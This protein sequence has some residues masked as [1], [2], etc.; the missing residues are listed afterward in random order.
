M[1]DQF[2]AEYE[3]QIANRARVLSRAR[4]RTLH[5]HPANG[6]IA[7]FL[8]QVASTLRRDG[9]AADALNSAAERQGASMLRGGHPIVD[10][11]QYYGDVCQAVTTLAAE[12]Q[13]P[14]S[15]E[16]F[17]VFN[18]CLDDAIENAVR[19]YNRVAEERRATADVQRLGVAVHELRDQLQ[20][21]HLSLRALQ[22]SGAPMGSRGNCWSAR[23]AT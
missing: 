11:V 14:I 15:A 4:D 17:S 19:E 16:D 8:T 21:A 10:V 5:E 1:L 18:R 3:E 7:A 13:V 2:I 12:R 6:E 23:S 20:T 22:S 9:V